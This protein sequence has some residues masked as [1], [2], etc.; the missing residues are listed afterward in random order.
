MNEKG[1]SMVDSLNQTFAAFRRLKEIL[2]EGERTAADQCDTCADF[3][4]PRPVNLRTKIEP[5][6][7]DHKRAVRSRQGSVRVVED[8]DAARFQ[9]ARGHGVVMWPC[10]T[11]SNWRSFSSVRDGR[12]SSFAF[13]SGF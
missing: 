4:A 12:C 11:V 1:F 2:L 13:S 8:L 9:H 5:Q 10:R 3:D 7:S 6:L